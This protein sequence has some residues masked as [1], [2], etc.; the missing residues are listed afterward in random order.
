MDDKRYEDLANTLKNSGL[1]ASMN[2]A[3]TMAKEMIGTGD[4]VQEDFQKRSNFITNKIEK[5][6]KEK[7]EIKKPKIEVREGKIKKVIKEEMIENA[8]KKEPF[9]IKNEYETPNKKEVIED[10]STLKDIMEEEAKEV[11][12]KTDKEEDISVKEV[13]SIEQQPDIDVNEMFDFTKRP[14][15]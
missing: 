6:K 13:N 2:E 14:C 5:I 15:E 3:M 12:E 4:K 7:L 9:I 1:A 8:Q 10:N 11:Y